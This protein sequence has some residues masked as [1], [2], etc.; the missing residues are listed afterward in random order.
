MGHKKV[1]KDRN[2]WKLYKQFTSSSTLTS[3]FK[4]VNFEEESGIW[5]KK[6]NNI[7][8]RSFPKIRVKRQSKS[9]HIQKYMEKRSILQNEKIKIQDTL[10]ISIQRRAEM[11]AFFEKEI[12]YLETL[13]ANLS[14]EKNAKIIGDQYSNLSDFGNFSLGKMW[15]LNRKLKYQNNDPTAKYDEKGNL[16]CD[17]KGLLSL[18]Q[19]EYYNRLLQKAPEKE[20]T[21]LQYLKEYLFNIRFEVSKL[22]KSKDCT[23]E[24]LLKVCSSLKNG[25]S[26]DPNGLIY[27]LFKNQYSGPDVRSSLY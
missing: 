23:S 4:G 10:Q 26:R 18:Y 20:Y 17:K 27:E 11:V 16:I 5:F 14:A 8:H 1:C 15:S 12:D 19:N 3:C 22:M 24:Q 25:K 13:I 21:E 7:L 9:D 6:F 2:R